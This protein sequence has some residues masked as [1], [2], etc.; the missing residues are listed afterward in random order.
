MLDNNDDEQK[1]RR[2]NENDLPIY[3]ILVP[4][5]HENKN[6]IL[7]IIQSISEINYPRDKLDIL[8]VLEENDAKTKNII[9]ILESFCNL[10]ENYYTKVYVPDFKPQTKPKACNVACLFASGDY[11]VIYDAEDRPQKYQLIDALEC[12]DKNKDLDVAQ[13]N[14]LFY[15]YKT[16]IL[17]EL[18]NIE[19]NVWFKIILRTISKF[20]IPMPLGGTSN[21]FK[22]TTL[23]KNGFWDGYN[24]TEDLEIGT[25]LN[26]KG[27]RMKHLNSDTKEWCVVNL[28]TWFRQRRRWM[29]GYMLT[30]FMYLFDRRNFKSLKT[31]V[32]LNIFVFYTSFCFLLIP[33]LIMSSLYWF[34]HPIMYIYMFVCVLYYLHYIVMYFVLSKKSIIKITPQTIFAFILYPFYFILHHIATWLAFYDIFRK[35]FYWGKTSHDL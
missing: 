33:L 21:H 13:C 19:Y 1:I 25:I 9:N 6:T 10:F 27:Y 11:V 24:V 22:F 18:F 26:Y 35:P 15:N 14:L 8:L 31:F 7:Q 12:F 17:T 2:Y 5:Y 30:T 29:K 20:K 3:T 28:K 34:F 23:E 16:N 4:V 32:Y